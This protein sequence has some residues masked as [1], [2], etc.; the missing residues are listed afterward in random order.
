MPERNEPASVVEASE[1]R[2]EIMEKIYTVNGTSVAVGTTD[3]LAQM[4]NLH[5]FQEGQGCSMQRS[6]LTDVDRFLMEHLSGERK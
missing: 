5:S 2:P 1:R 3:F 4:E 6:G